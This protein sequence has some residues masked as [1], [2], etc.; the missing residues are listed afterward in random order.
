MLEPQGDASWE[1][2]GLR[3]HWPES[4]AAQ[5]TL[6]QGRGASVPALVLSSGPAKA[7]G[8]GSYTSC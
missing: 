8:F 7:L 3:K 6:G 1:F 5:R 4:R 2:S